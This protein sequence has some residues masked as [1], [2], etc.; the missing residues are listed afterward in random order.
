MTNQ[1]A[2]SS[3]GPTHLPLSI[4][5][6]KGVSIT[7]ITSAS[8][9]WGPRPQR[10]CHSECRCNRDEESRGGGR[11]FAA[12]R[13]TWGEWRA[14]KSFLSSGPGGFA[15]SASGDLTSWYTLWDCFVAFGFSQWRVEA[16]CCRGG[17]CP[18]PSTYSGVWGHSPHPLPSSRVPTH[19]PLSIRGTKGVTI[20]IILSSR[21]LA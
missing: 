10:R 20:I 7:I 17:A 21:G 16:Y 13:M 18:R 2:T 19:L 9:A 4:R 5:G 3:R 8:G 14:T 12:L 1:P 11:S 6:T 15:P